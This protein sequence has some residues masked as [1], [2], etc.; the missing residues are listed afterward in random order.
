[1]RFV[2]LPLGTYGDLLPHLEIA[3]ELHRRGHD[4]IIG[5][6]EAFR[7][8]VEARQLLFE[9]IISDEQYQK[10]LAD[11]KLWHHRHFFETYARGWMCPAVKPIVTLIQSQPQP[12]ELILV[13]SICGGPGAQ[14]AAEL[15]GAKTVTL[16][17]EPAAILSAKKPPVLSGMSALPSLPYPLRRLFLWGISL[18][19]DRLIAGQI[20]TPRK[21]LGLKPVNNILSWLASKEK[22]L[23]LFPD[24]YC[25]KQSDWPPHLKHVGFPLSNNKPELPKEVEL[26]LESGPPPIVITFGTGMQG[27]QKLFSIA[28]DAC[29]RLGERALLISPQ[30]DNLQDKLTNSIQTFGPVPFSTLLPRA[31][32]IIH[33]AGNGTVAQALASGIPQIGIPMAHDQFDSL[34]RIRQLGCGDGIPAQKANAYRLTRIIENTLG[35]QTIR[36]SCK[37]LAIRLEKN[38]GITI[39]GDLLEHWQSRAIL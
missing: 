14:T 2:F 31:R 37:Q 4:V 18:N 8:R 11:P 15:T 9:P 24:W 25:R 12:E 23:A 28:A 39:A 1:M 38:N 20:N 30:E 32:A 29:D 16:W 19:A 7:E 33:H 6:A 22:Q 17:V 21:E 13:S 3:T 27:A 34:A 35:S 36:Q 10:V 5:T 26:F